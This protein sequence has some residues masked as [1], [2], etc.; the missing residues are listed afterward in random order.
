MRIRIVDAG[1][2]H[3]L[4]IDTGAEDHASSEKGGRK[5]GAAAASRTKEECSR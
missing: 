5:G 3:R 1:K 2:M 4:G